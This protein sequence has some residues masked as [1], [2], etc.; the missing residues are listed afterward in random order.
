MFVCM[1]VCISLR[2]EDLIFPL[3][4]CLYICLSIGLCG[5]GAIPCAYVYSHLCVDCLCCYVSGCLPAAACLTACVPVN[6]ICLI[7]LRF[8]TPPY[9]PS[10]GCHSSIPG[11]GMVPHHRE[12]YQPQHAFLVSY[13]LSVLGTYP[14]HPG[15]E[16]PREELQAL[17]EREQSMF[18]S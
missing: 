6:K 2:S 10:L 15:Y 4:S 12:Q 16:A 17:R 1:Y 7:C 13:C 3:P 14:V 8:L 11:I 5:L 9:S 18:V